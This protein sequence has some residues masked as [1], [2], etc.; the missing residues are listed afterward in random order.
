VPVH[1]IGEVQAIDGDKV[2]LSFANGAVRRFKRRFVS[3]VKS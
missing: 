3:P 2:E 1:G